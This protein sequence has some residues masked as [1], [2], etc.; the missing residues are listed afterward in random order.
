MNLDDMVDEATND[1][2]EVDFSAALDFTPLV[3]DFRF[4]VEEAVVGKTGPKAKLPNSPKITLKCVVVSGLDK[5]GVDKTGRKA[6]KDLPMAGEGSGI[7][8]Q[9]I[10]MFSEEYD[11]PEL[12]PDYVAENGLRASLFVGLEFTGSCRISKFNEDFT[13][14]FRVKAPVESE[15]V[16]L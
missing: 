9:A 1:V 8:K 3:G 12:A 11:I 16:G 6:M 13:D 4:R 14:I 5:E 10:A 2:L 15:S 7:T